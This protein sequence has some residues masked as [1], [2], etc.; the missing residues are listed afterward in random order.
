M[1][2]DAQQL[3]TLF[4]TWYTTVLLALFTHTPC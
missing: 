4:G 2:M 1:Y 3:S